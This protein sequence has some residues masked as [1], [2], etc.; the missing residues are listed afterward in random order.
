MLG[1]ERWREVAERYGLGLMVGGVQAAIDAGEIAP[2]AAGR[3]RPADGGADEA[4]LLVVREPDATDA[5]AATL[6][7]LIEGLRVAPGS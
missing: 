6:E 5:V 4:A 1:W 3:P 7:R 2:V